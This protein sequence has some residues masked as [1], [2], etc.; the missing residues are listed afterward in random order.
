MKPKPRDYLTIA[1]ALI[2][3][4]LCGYGIGFLVGEH[5][6][7]QRLGPDRGS[8]PGEQQDWEAAT[9]ERLSTELRLTEDQKSAIREEIRTASGE[10]SGARNRALQDYRKSLLDLHERLLPHLTDEQRQRVEESRQQF[11]EMLD[12]EGKV[13]DGPSD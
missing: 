2:A 7:Q 1:A 4:L 5:T 6:T 11:L 3:I 8:D 10:I 13:S 12:K 9:L